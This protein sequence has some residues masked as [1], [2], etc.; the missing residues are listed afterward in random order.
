L[1]YKRH[2]INNPISKGK[3]GYIERKDQTKARQR[4]KQENTV[5]SIGVCLVLLTLL[6]FDTEYPTKATSWWKNMGD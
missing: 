4:K 1:K 2:R 6:I 3:N 5:N